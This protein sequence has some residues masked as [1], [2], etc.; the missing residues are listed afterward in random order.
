[1]GLVAVGNTVDGTRGLTAD[2]VVIELVS[3][4]VACTDADVKL[5]VSLSSLKAGCVDIGSKSEESS[6]SI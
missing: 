3:W 2:L 4:L 1:M 5:M 6:A